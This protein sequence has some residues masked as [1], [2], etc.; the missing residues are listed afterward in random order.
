MALVIDHLAYLAV[1]AAL[2]FVVEADLS[3]H[4]CRRRTDAD[5]RGELVPTPSWIW[6]DHLSPGN[7]IS[8]GGRDQFS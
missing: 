2:R 1:A 8:G 3:A 5:G 6:H 7:K 4:Q